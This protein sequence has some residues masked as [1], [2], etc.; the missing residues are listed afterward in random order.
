[1]IMRTF[2]ILVALL[3]VVLATPIRAAERSALTFPSK[4]I[5]ADPNL[6]N[7]IPLSTDLFKT[8]DSLFCSQINVNPFADLSEAMDVGCWNEK[9]SYANY[10]D[11][12][13]V[14]D[15]M[16]LEKDYDVCKCLKDPTKNKV[17]AVRKLMDTSTVNLPNYKMPKNALEVYKQNAEELRKEI[18]KDKDGIAFHASIISLAKPGFVNL[19]AQEHFKDAKKSI[20]LKESSLDAKSELKKIFD[21]FVIPGTSKN[22]LE[23]EKYSADQC[24]GGRE[25]LAYKQMPEDDVLKEINSVDLKN[26]KQEDWDYNGLRK[27][28]DRLMSLNSIDKKF[29]KSKIL[30]LKAKM[31]FLGRNPFLKQFFSVNT[32]LGYL[33]NIKNEKRRQDVTKV[34]ET[35]K[36]QIEKLKIKLFTKLKDVSKDISCE[37]SSTSCLKQIEDATK[38]YNNGL[39]EFFT[40]SNVVELMNIQGEKDAYKKYEKLADAQNLSPKSQVFTQEGVVA[41]FVKATGLKSP[42]H[43][44]KGGVNVTECVEIYAAYCKTLDG[45]MPKLRST[46]TDPELV[47]DLDVKLMNVMDADLA[48]NVELQQLN[49]ELCSSPR[50]KSEKD[51]KSNPETFFSYKDKYCN[52]HKSAPECVS[53]SPENLRA[54]R[55]KFFTEYPVPGVPGSKGSSR[56]AQRLSAVSRNGSLRNMPSHLLKPMDFSDADSRNR[57]LSQLRSTWGLDKSSVAEVNKTN[58]FEMLSPQGSSSQSSQ[59]IQEASVASPINY[60]QGSMAPAQDVPKIEN[61]NEKEKR[62]LQDDW[63]KE[64]EAMKAKNASSPSEASL[65]QQIAME[66]RLEALQKALEDQQKITAEQSRLLNEAI[67]AQTRTSR[68]DSESDEPVKKSRDRENTVAS[69]QDTSSDISRS[70]ASIKDPSLNS[71]GSNSGS[72]VGSTSVSSSRKGSSNALSDGSVERETAKLV[73]LRRH[74]DGTISIEPLSSGGVASSNAIT[75]S[76]T[77]DQYQQL[78]AN[79]N[80]FNLSTLEKNIPKD[81]IDILDK[82]GEIVLLIKDLMNPTNP[83]LEVQVEKKENKLVYRLK[84]KKGQSVK[85]VKRVYTRQALELQLKVQR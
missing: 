39:A 46:E 7:F 10:V 44:S 21:G 54:L 28:Y 67:A 52:G 38:N 75:L 79:P 27:E 60:A 32:D 33:S 11:R 35:N 26:F 68:P 22:V 29:N 40:Q 25:F 13:G 61:M 80:G 55:E 34:I 43:C 53:S 23:D 77:D 64:Y 50:R 69:S 9:D 81:Q 66:K 16:L 71:G 84:D 83:T 31:T 6:G 18:I 62:E 20:N 37:N 72:F 78:Q 45:V 24:I 4:F 5:D 17:E 63:Q 14:T 1:M 70:P 3:C 36:A 65:A 42:D 48:S 41:S 2:R 51:R 59:N 19:Y 30:G 47:D 73:N 56:V 76:V 74:S 8:Q 82:K 15:K 58:D 85:P 49:K 57:E 12:K